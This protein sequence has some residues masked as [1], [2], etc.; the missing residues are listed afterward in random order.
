ME[1]LILIFELM[2]TSFISQIKCIAFPYHNVSGFRIPLFRIGL[3]DVS[4]T[5]LSISFHLLQSSL[6][7][8]SFSVQQKVLQHSWY[9]FAYLKLHIQVELAVYSY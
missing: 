4:V 5:F 6:L 9:F 3:A 1:L 2:P 8:C 7:P